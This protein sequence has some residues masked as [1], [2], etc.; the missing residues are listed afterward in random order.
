MSDPYPIFYQNVD[1]K[2]IQLIKETADPK[3]KIKIIAI[4]YFIEKKKRLDKKLESEILK[5]QQKKQDQFLE[6]QSIENQI[7]QGS[8]QLDKNN[9]QVKYAF[10]NLPQYFTSEQMREDKEYD[11]D[12]PLEGYWGKGDEKL[13]DAIT[14]I[15]Y[16]KDTS[17]PAHPH[18]F[19][20]SFYF[21]TKKE[22]I[23]QIFKGQG[24]LRKTFIMYNSVMPL[25]SEVQM[26]T[27]TGFKSDS[28]FSFF[29]ARN[30]EDYIDKPEEERKKAERKMGRDF[31][32]A[33][34]LIQELIPY[35]LEYYLELRKEEDNEKDLEKEIKYELEKVN[36]QKQQ[37][38][39]FEKTKAN[40]Q[41][42][43]C[44]IQ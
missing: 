33:Q 28:F 40:L 3:E 9:P 19:T 27:N 35:S 23:K 39:V 41:N 2:M 43:E 24:V 32:I 18:N 22:E 7:I 6:Y 21:D 15:D 5:L 16:M 13:I 44:Q 42:L 12:V 26:E 38:T 37:A 25:S 11:M 17:D 14:K 31:E 10:D 1:E 34:L 30:L 4:N 36:K 8:L 20:I 29:T